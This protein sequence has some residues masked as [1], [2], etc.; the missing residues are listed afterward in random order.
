MYI[1]K[2]KVVST[3]DINLEH[4][5]PGLDEAITEYISTDYLVF[6]HIRSWK[7]DDWDYI[8]QALKNAYK[9]LLKEEKFEEGETFIWEVE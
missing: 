4:N 1:P 8:P 5:C 3:W 6:D 9:I 7:D 2:F